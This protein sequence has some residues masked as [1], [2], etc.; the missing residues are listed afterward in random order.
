MPLAPAADRSPSD[1]ELRVGLGANAHDAAVEH[2]NA[3]RQG[4]RNQE[5]VRQVATDRTM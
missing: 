2:H 5:L 4:E 3:R 1:L